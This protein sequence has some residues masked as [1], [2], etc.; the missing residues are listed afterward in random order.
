MKMFN[1]VYKN[2]ILQQ[3]LRN[4]KIIKNDKNNT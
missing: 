4:M 2:M 3:K 1:N